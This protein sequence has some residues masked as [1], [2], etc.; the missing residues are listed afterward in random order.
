MFFPI[1]LVVLRGTVWTMRGVAWPNTCGYPTAAGG[2][3]KRQVR[4][5]WRKCWDHRRS[6]VRRTDGHRIDPALTRWK[7]V[8]GTGERLRGA[9]FVSR[10][11]AAE[12]ALFQAEGFARPPAE[13]VAYL[14]GEWPRAWR[15]RWA[16]IV[17]RAR[18]IRVSGVVGIAGGAPVGVS[19]RAFVA[20]DVARAILVSL[21]GGLVATTASALVHGVGSVTADY[22]AALYFVHMWMAARFGLWEGVT[23][24]L[25]KSVRGSAVWLAWGLMVALLGGLLGVIE[26]AK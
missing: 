6:R 18:S 10:H 22:V 11:R 4:G 15:L 25:R 9:G 13:V 5:E 21:L 12:T 1:G 20:S 17:R 14:T 26:G 24:W 8:S 16:A 19:S 3:C 7:S 23:D 2:F